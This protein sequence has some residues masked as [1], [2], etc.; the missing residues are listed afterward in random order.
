MGLEG[1]VMGSHT[2]LAL[3][4]TTTARA[5]ASFVGAGDCSESGEH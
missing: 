5:A 4:I 2:S 3:S 1:L